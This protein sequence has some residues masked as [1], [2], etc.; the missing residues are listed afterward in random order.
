[1]SGNTRPY[2]V[3]PAAAEAKLLGVDGR[4]LLKILHQRCNLDA[5]ISLAFVGSDCEFGF[6]GLLNPA[7]PL[8]LPFVTVFAEARLLSQLCEAFSRLRHQ[9]MVRQGRN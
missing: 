7:A 6:S 8:W 2:F 3:H 4:D 1:M 9:L 5:P